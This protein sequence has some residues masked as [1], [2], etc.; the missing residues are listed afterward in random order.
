MHAGEGKA[1]I[2]ATKETGGSATVNASG[3]HI[4]AIVR[5]SSWSMRLSQAALRAVA[6]AE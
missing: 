5:I 3:A 6:C 4:P 1:E 2:V